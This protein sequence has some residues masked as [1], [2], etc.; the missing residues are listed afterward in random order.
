MQLHLTALCGSCCLSTARGKFYFYNE[1]F[2]V[3][4]DNDISTVTYVTMYGAL[5]CVLQLIFP[6]MH[7]D[8]EILVHRWWCACG[9]KW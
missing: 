7:S 3:I 9:A 5:K 2:R 8:I 4:L 6:S 1:I